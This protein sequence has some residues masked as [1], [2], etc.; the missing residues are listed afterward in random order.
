MSIKTII[1]M[2]ETHTAAGLTASVYSNILISDVK[3]LTPEKVEQ[4]VTALRTFL[5]R[6][7]DEGK[8]GHPFGTFNAN[9]Y[10]METK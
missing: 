1:S 10:P 5:T 2:T 6:C 7:I 8:N 3:E 4:A 9:C